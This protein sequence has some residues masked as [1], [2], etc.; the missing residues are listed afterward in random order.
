LKFSL[1][2][3]TAPL[4]S[5][6]GLNVLKS[7]YSDQLR[8]IKYWDQNSLTI[9][10][11]IDDDEQRQLR[12]S[13]QL[14]TFSLSLRILNF[15]VVEVMTHYFVNVEELRGKDCISLIWNFCGFT[16]IPDWFPRFSWFNSSKRIALNFERE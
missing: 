3:C 5:E 2:R 11:L 15:W 6:G 9:P 1:T 16:F 4:K 8:R 7:K 14:L 12:E 10:M 13:F